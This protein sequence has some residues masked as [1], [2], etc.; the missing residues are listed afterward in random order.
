MCQLVT[1]LGNRTLLLSCE[2]VFWNQPSFLP[3]C[4]KEK[5]M[6]GVE[7]IIYFKNCVWL[8]KDIFFSIADVMPVTFKQICQ[9][10]KICLMDIGDLATYKTIQ[11]V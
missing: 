1:Y 11:I 2:H 7:G 8:V 3:D 10:L 9:G 4:E 5:H 6:G